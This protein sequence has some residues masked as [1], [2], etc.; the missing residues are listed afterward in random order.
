MAKQLYWDE[1]PLTLK[2]PIGGE[3]WPATEF[4]SRIDATKKKQT[5]STIAFFCP[6]DHC[7]NLKKAMASGM[8][9]KDQG[10]RL[11]AAAE[12]HVAAYRRCNSFDDI[13]KMQEKYGP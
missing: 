3:E 1:I 11:L 6:A 10:R 5:P 4:K 13:A 8:F 9:T 7:F 2:C 12:E